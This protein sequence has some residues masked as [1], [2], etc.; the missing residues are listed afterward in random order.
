MS[1][2]RWPM[3]SREM[4]VPEI[5]G[6]FGPVASGLIVNSCVSCLREEMGYSLLAGPQIIE[7]PMTLHVFHD[8]ARSC[9]RHANN[10]GRGYLKTQY[11]PTVHPDQNKIIGSENDKANGENCPALAPD[12]GPIRHE[13]FASPAHPN[14]EP[15]SHQNHQPEQC[16]EA[17]PECFFVVH[18][19]ISDVLLI[20]APAF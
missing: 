7:A 9:T 14:C 17:E 16:P 13:P 5:E 1:D 20:R 15:D 8:K 2:K 6:M 3:P 18:P 12:G 4:V 11:D 19:R 10:S